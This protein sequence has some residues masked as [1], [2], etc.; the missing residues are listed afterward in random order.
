M[1][2]SRMLFFRDIAKKKTMGRMAFI[3]LYCSDK[4]LPK[5][6]IF[7]AQ[8][9]AFFQPTMAISLKEACASC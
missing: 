9:S 8:D 1:A 3:Y 7:A 4:T 5:R 6:D 2:Q